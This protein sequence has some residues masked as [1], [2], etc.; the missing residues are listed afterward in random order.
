MVQQGG[1]LMADPSIYD[2]LS[3]KQL[4]EVTV[5]LLNSASKVSY[6][7]DKSVGFWA[8]PITLQRI[9][10]ASRTYSWGLPIPELGAV[11]QVSISDSSSS[12]F[13]PSGTE[14]WRVQLMAG[15]GALVWSLNDGSNQA[16]YF[17]GTDPVKPDNLFLTNSLYLTATNSSGDTVTAQVAYHKVGL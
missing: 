3:K 7:D 2:L 9:L 16:I 14:V 10:E 8:G 5:S 12:S 15:S 17:S 4:S 1:I 6:V 11:S 13:Q